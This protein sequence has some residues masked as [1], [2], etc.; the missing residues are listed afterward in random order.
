MIM[1][2][3]RKSQIAKFL[4]IAVGIGFLLV[5]MNTVATETRSLTSTNATTESTGNLLA[6]E[7]SPYL[8]EASQQ[9]VH[10][11]PWSQA[12]FQHAQEEDK[13]ILLDIG[14]V[15]FAQESLPLFGC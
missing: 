15:G 13:P 4:K 1:N 9:P 5:P 2:R 11:R 8:R 6:G 12:A 7:A 10:W 14:A 3:F